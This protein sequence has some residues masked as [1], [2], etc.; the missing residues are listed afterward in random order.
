MNDAL[1]KA[2]QELAP[3]GRLRVSINLGNPILAGRTE[4]G[5]L[6]GVS[7]DLASELGRELGLDI[8]LKPYDAA[9]KAVEAL[10]SGDVD[11]GFFAIDPARSQGIA[12]TAPYVLIEGAYLVREDSPLTSGEQVDQ[13]GHDVVVGAGSAY[14]LF[15]TRHLQRAR[16]V[17]APT[18][19]TV[20]DEF[21]QG[22]FAAA[23][24][25]KQQLEAD[26][27]RYPASRLLPESFMVI[28]QAMGAADR[29][30]PTTRSMLA[31][32]I[33]DMKAKGDIAR[34]LSRHGIEGA[35]VAPPSGCQ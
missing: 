17:R 1:K 6:F 16:I 31:T 15:L 34:F 29:I 12:F 30:S 28:Q 23:A 20:V 9:G 21:M 18:S 4:D 22:R 24:G 11:V 14:D 19:P 10:R 35:T 26:R 27:R 33:E 2:C 3:T 8:L 32:F 13:A 25:V 5:R 7:V